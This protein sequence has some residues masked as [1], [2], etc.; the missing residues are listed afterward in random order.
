MHQTEQVGEAYQSTVISVNEDVADVNA[1]IYL[2]G[3]RIRAL[4][5]AN[6]KSGPGGQ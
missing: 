2:E 4:K 3:V 5:T 6:I 1:S